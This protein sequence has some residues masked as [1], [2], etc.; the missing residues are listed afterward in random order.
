[1]I[2]RPRRYDNESATEIAKGTGSGADDGTEF[3]WDCLGHGGRGSNRAQPPHQVAKRLA[4]GC[5]KRL[6][7]LPKLKMK[8]R[9]HD[10]LARRGFNYDIVEDVVE[11]IMHR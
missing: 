3:Q 1:M 7:D 10:Y 5:V 2:Q 9:L 4:E 8:K 11:N 6:K